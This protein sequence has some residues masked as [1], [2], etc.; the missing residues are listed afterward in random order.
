MEQERKQQRETQ[1]T[2]LISGI[3]ELRNL[4]EAIPEGTVYSLDLSEV[5]L[6]DE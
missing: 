1:D 3:S 5:I 4:I 2:V 6:T